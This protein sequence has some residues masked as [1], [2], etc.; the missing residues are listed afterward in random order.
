MMMG[1][2]H[3]RLFWD[4]GFTLLE[5]ILYIAIVSAVTISIVMFSFTVMDARDETF[6]IQEVH[7]NSRMALEEI[8]ARVRAAS[9]INVGASVFDSDPGVLSLTMQDAQKDPTVIT[10]DADDGA[11]EITEG[12]SSPI[13]VTSDEVKV[14]NLLF[15]NL[16][17]AQKRENVGIQFS[18]EYNSILPDA[19]LDYSHSWGT[20]INI[21]Q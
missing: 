16:T 20:S 1:K 8:S 5:L 10:L 21:R 9:S 7:A 19:I 11:L 14:T 2:K 15:S 12:A 3:I 18:V 6:A 13:L 17:P 4:S